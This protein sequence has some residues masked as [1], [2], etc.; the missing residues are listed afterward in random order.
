M[1][2]SGQNRYG[3]Y[4]MLLPILVCL[5][6]QTGCASIEHVRLYH[7]ARSDFSAAAHEDNLA[8]LQGIFP[9][10]KALSGLTND[11]SVDYVGVQA[12]VE[13][14]ET[15][16]AEFRALNCRKK[17]ELSDDQLL[18]SSLTLQIIAQLRRDLWAHALSPDDKQNQDLEK[19]D[20]PSSQGD[21]LTQCGSPQ[22]SPMP[23]TDTLAQAEALAAN[24]GVKLFE[25]DEFLL[26]S[27]RPMVRYEIAYIN[28][29][30]ADAEFKNRNKNKKPGEKP[31]DTE[32]KR[33]AYIPIV[34]QMV[35]AEKKLS[36]LADKSPSTMKPYV[37]MSRYIMLVSSQALVA[38][39]NRVNVQLPVTQEKDKELYN[40]EE[41]LKKLNDRIK[42]FRSNAGAGGK[43]ENDLIKKIGLGT[44]DIGRNLDGSGLPCV[45]GKDLDC[46]EGGASP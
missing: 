35:Q 37:T 1:E 27:L 9:N 34:G 23:L 31:V 2:P 39:P 36:E 8:T 42:N 10:P 21:P 30:K 16:L 28:T 3:M 20:D 19:L 14:W 18:G 38:D 11:A 17:K 15:V 29:I 12:S 44:G 43:P 7:D 26:R 22:Q 41:K 25:R 24:K 33:K 46:T 13:R 32:E 45:V 40:K 5:L 4:W 6:I